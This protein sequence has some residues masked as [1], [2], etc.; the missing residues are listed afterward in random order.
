MKKIIRLPSIAVIL[1]GTCLAFGMSPASAGPP[2]G[3]CAGYE[4][5]LNDGIPSKSCL[6][7]SPQVI[8]LEN[9]QPGIVQRT[10]A[11]GWNPP[12]CWISNSFWHG[13]HSPLEN[14]PQVGNTGEV[15]GGIRIVVDNGNCTGPTFAAGLRA[16]IWT[17]INGLNRCGYTSYNPSQAAVGFDEYGSGCAPFAVAPGSPSYGAWNGGYYGVRV[18]AWLDT[19]GSVD[20]FSQH[21]IYL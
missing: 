1:I 17:R 18:V 11:Y 13:S 16:E 12:L 9:R 14:N 2:Y 20:V 15:S 21:Q 7:N 5:T 6:V 3:Y 10:P 19:G 4:Y 8:T